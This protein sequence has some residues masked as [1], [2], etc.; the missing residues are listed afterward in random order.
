MPV[1]IQHKI[2]VLCYSPLAEA[3]LTGKFASAADVPEWRARTRHFSASRKL[4]RHGEEGMEEE[5]FE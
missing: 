1:C 2:S 3:L 5:T 4:V